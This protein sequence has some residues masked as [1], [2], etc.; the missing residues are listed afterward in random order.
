MVDCIGPIKLGL[1]LFMVMVPCCGMFQDMS[2]FESFFV[3]CG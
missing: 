3:L 2:V 1:G